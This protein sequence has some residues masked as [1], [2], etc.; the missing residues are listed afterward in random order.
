MAKKCNKMK[1]LYILPSLR[2][3]GPVVVAHDLVSE[4]I[5]HGHECSVVYFDGGE[6]LTFPCET[7]C[8]SMKGKCDFKKYDVVHAHGFRPQLYVTIHKPLFCK[9]KF[10]TTLH[11][12]VFNDFR[13]GYGQVK[14]VVFSFLHLATCLRFDTIVTLSQN[15]KHYY[16]RFFPLKNIQVAYNTTCRDANVGLSP[17][18]ITKIQAFKGD[19]FLL[20]TCC[21]LIPRKRVE[22]VIK[23]LPKLPTVK[24]LVVG[25]GK[26]K[27]NLEDLATKL[28]VSDRVL[29]VGKK[30]MGYRYMKLFDAFTLTSTSEGFPLSLLEAASY[31]TPAITSN[32]PVYHELFS[33]REIEILPSIQEDDVAASVY[34]VMQHRF[35]LSAAIRN[36]FISTY[37][38]EKFY[39]RYLKIYKE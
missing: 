38:P 9:T 2:N 39:T 20:G 12:F 29:F 10:V 13:Y 19:D 11:N 27:V 34:Y 4:F 6:E 32:L 8:V 18:E 5:A 33:N 16:R 26:E 3:K 24:F 36:K 15:A 31:G 30:P 17:E 37:S 23:A 21:V 1:I 22:V 35:E 28:G 14:G 7:R 25:D